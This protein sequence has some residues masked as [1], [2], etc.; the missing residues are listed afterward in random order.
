M[1]AS[2]AAFCAARTTRLTWLRFL[3]WVS[4]KYSRVSGSPALPSVRSWFQALQLPLPCTRYTYS[5][6][7][8]SPSTSA[9]WWCDT[10]FSVFSSWVFARTWRVPSMAGESPARAISSS[11]ACTLPSVRQATAK[12]WLGSTDGEATMRSGTVVAA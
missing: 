4:P 3:F 10:P 6:S 8:F 2:G 12:P 1:R 11:G 7:G 5:V 9:R